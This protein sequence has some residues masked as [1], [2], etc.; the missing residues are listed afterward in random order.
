MKPKKTGASAQSIKA[1]KAKPQK[2]KLPPDLTGLNEGFAANARPVIA[3]YHRISGADRETLVRDLLHDI[4]HLCD[5]DPSLGNFH[6]QH[7]WAVNLYGA[8]TQEY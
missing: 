6:Q 2:L 7:G 5:R 4:M 3:L 8:L 1:L